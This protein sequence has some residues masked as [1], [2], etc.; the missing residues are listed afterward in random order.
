M[1]PPLI[2][3]LLSKLNQ[4]H[5]SGKVFDVN[6][7]NF[8]CFLVIVSIFTVYIKISSVP[9][10]GPRR[11]LPDRRPSPHAPP[12]W[13]CHPDRRATP[14]RRGLST[15]VPRRVPTVVAR[16]HSRRCRP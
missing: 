15:P 16:F 8:T 12:D 2:Y 9:S 6:V 11:I 3:N 7:P 5:F 13:T 1:Y 14:R 10:I 4:E